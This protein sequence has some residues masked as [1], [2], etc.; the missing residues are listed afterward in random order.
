MGFQKI[1]ANNTELIEGHGQS[2][3]DTTRPK[4]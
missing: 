1:L 3:R 4:C 2:V